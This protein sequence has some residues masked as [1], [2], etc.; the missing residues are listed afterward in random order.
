LAVAEQGGFSAGARALGHTQGAVSQAVQALERDLGEPLFLREGRRV[1]LTQ[2]GSVLRMHA[3]RAF[4]ELRAAY[5]ELSARSALTRGTLTIGTTDTLAAHLLPNA[6]AS[7]R[8]L[9]PGL[10]LRLVLKPSPAIALGVATRKLD[11]GVVSLPLPTRLGRSRRTTSELLEARS[12][13]AQR[14]VAIVPKKHPLARKARVSFAELA[15][16]PMLLLD[17][18]TA[19]R[20]TMEARFVALSLAPR[21][22]MEMSSVEVLKKLVSLGFGVSIVPE[23][24]TKE[25][26]RDGFV[27]LELSDAPTRTVGCITPR[28]GVPSHAARAWLD[29]LTKSLAKAGP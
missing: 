24:A 21:V 5:D 23:I 19:T 27:T 6:L 22:L 26:A 12:L 29:V 10:D 17:R 28:A 25:A 1:L 2:A 15:L 11:V 20:A 18:T 4:T 3:E 13:T 9:H 8:A 16:H 14:D 7:F